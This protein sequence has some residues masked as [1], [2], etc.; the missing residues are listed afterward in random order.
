M[1]TIGQPVNRVNGSL[2]V[3]GAATYA[4]DYR[5]ANMLY[6]VPVGSTIAAGELLSLDLS[7]A[8][9]TPGVV[10]IF[11]HDNF[12]KLREAPSTGMPDGPDPIVDERRPPLSDTK[13]RY[14]GQYIALVVGETF[15]A[16]SE[17]AMLVRATYRPTDPATPLG[18]EPTGPAREENARGDVDS[19]F[20]AAPVRHRRG[21]RDPGRNP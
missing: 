9:A 16:A 20:A 12:E 21:V 3:T 5:L 7:A 13:I 2:K 10:E 11:H 8:R 17:G 18:G 6:G 1:S 15:E 14:Y 19:A 4:A